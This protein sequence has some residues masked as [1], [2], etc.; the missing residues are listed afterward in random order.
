[1]L[2]RFWTT[3]FFLSLPIFCWGQSADEQF[4]F[5]KSLYRDG[6][7][8]IAVEQFKQFAELYPTS[9]HADEAQFLAAECYYAGA[10]W[11]SAVQWYRT[12]L[13]GYPTSR[14]VAQAWFKLGECDFHRRYYEDAIESFGQVRKRYPTSEE[15]P[16]SLQRIGQCYDALNQPHQ[17]LET[18]QRFLDEYPKH[19]D[20]PR[21]RLTIGEIYLNLE[22]WEKANETFQ[23]IIDRHSH[24]QEIA[25]KARLQLA[26]VL[27]RQQKLEQAGAAYQ[28]VVANYPASVYADDAQLGLGLV[29]AE[30]G[31]YTESINEL[32]KVITLF[33]Q[34]DL[35]DDAIYHMAEAWRL[36]GNHFEARKNYE[37]LIRN[38]PRSEFLASAQ[39]GLALALSAEGKVYAAIE[40]FEKLVK[41]FP[42]T[43]FARAAQLQI[44]R[45]YTDKGQ[46]LNGV[47][48]YRQYIAAN[49]GLPTGEQLDIMFE[50]ARIL[51]QD[52]QH[53]DM[54]VSAYQD[55]VIA[56]PDHP[57]AARA[58]FAAGLNY[59]N[60]ENFAAARREYERLM[61]RYPKSPYYLQA[62]NRIEFIDDFLLKE[63]DP[64]LEKLAAGLEKVIANRATGKDLF[65]LAAVFYKQ[66]RLFD[67]SIRLLEEFVRQHPNG[68]ETLSAQM[69]IADSYDKIARRA[70]D[71]DDF[72]QSGFNFSK[73]RGVYQEIVSRFGDSPE[74]TAAAA[75]ILR[76]DLR[77]MSERTPVPYDQMI[78]QCQQF[79]QRYPA[80]PQEPEVLFR[81]G[82]L[83]LTKLQRMG[84]DSYPAEQTLR[85]LTTDFGNS[86]YVPEATLLLGRL[87]EMQQN[88]VQADAFYSQVIDFYSR[89]P[90]MPEALYARGLLNQKQARWLGAIQDFERLVADYGFH[91]RFAESLLHIGEC[92]THI[93]NYPEAIR[94]YST[95]LLSDTDASIK[96][97]AAFLIGQ[98]LNQAKRH[99]ESTEALQ[100]FLQD[101]PASP[102]LEQAYLLIAENHLALGD[103]DSAV[104]VYQKLDEEQPALSVKLK[105]ADLQF[106]TERYD[107][108]YASYQALLTPQMDA[109][110]EFRIQFQSL[111]CL[112]RQNKIQTADKD[113]K[114]F[115]KDYKD[116]P[117]EMATILIE[118]AN[119]FLRQK[120]FDRAR[121][122]F[123]LVMREYPQTDS[124]AE[125]HYGLGM[126]Y[127]SSSDYASS[128][129]VFEQITRNYPG[130]ELSQRAYFR[131]GTALFNEQQF[132]T[133]ATA[134]ARLLD[135][136]DDL[137]FPEAHYNYA[138]ALEKA[139]RWSD[140]ANAYR[141]FTEKL[142]QHELAGRAFFKIGYCLFEDGQYREAI[143]ALRFSLD[144]VEGDDKAE[145]QYWLGESLFNIG[146]FQSAAIE[147]L[148]VP[149]LYP[150]AMDGMW[151]LTADFKAALAHEKMGEY[152]EA[153]RLYRKIIDRQGS[154][155][156]WGRAA[157]ERLDQLGE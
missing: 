115:K 111:R 58:M 50:V 42:N 99:T 133:A 10:D 125:A 2:K 49:P 105:I 33:A 40:N 59:E 144:K 124:Y 66:L 6:M 132:E 35:K 97:D 8:S 16:L 81:L 148:K 131:L 22:D 80:T 113:A 89:D 120:Q 71:K 100:Q 82:S 146:D 109:E 76:Y 156:Q 78:F 91:Q 138:L 65:D 56:F 130:T 77:E 116:R 12:F 69:M 45:T 29:L 13:A 126:Y 9:V 48:A 98:T 135:T 108:A 44:A 134:Y 26:R 53:Y 62:Q 151:G 38:Y 57:Q 93:K 119:Y 101:Y 24:H 31:H 63:Y 83:M 19:D 68:A 128:I 74:V 122:N 85:R 70:L 84:G 147:F 114:K 23:A 104:K 73:A 75:Q 137:K 52:V 79:L 20:N 103:A 27:H 47:K 55:I 60:L 87:T 14:L 5:A 121:E 141:R 140:A 11:K 88:Y 143:D 102:R 46:H 157:R 18:Y 136:D 150:N 142:G 64:A 154:D 61:E 3:V 139:T 94:T 37:D 25:E 155:S 21:I 4:N 36:K 107:K 145:A 7:Y 43:D 90:V 129:P 149:Y 1:M 15:A 152:V 28:H 30:Q 112:Y 118:E 123:D 72:Y 54:A 39:Y 95:L 117:N 86:E 92:Y 96:A 41:S 110:I 17:A 34:S 51:D 67:T 106:D 32:T 153:T 127:F